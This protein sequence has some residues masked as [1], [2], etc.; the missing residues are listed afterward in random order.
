MMLIYATV[1]EVEVRS[2]RWRVEDQLAAY[3]SAV[4]AVFTPEANNSNAAAA[5]SS[6]SVELLPVDEEQDEEVQPQ[7]TTLP[8]QPAAVAAATSRVQQQ[9]QR[10]QQQPK[11]EDLPKTRRVAYQGMCY[12]AAFIC[13]YIF[14]TTSRILMTAGVKPPPYPIRFLAVSSVSSQGFW[15]WLVYSVQVRRSLCIWCRF[16]LRRR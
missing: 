13:C 14:P 4:S 9:P 2:M 6:R 7:E 12:T 15:N 16:R 1:R 11:L 3:T 5:S 8:E 10:P